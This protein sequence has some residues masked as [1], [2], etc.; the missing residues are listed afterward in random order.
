MDMGS[1]EDILEKTKLDLKLKVKQA[2]FQY[3][4][5]IKSLLFSKKLPKECYSC[6]PTMLFIEI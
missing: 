3:Y 5:T 6:I 2:I 1:L 4:L